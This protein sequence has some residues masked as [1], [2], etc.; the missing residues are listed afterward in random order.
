MK[1]NLKNKIVFI[2]GASSGIGK[3]LVLAFSS[4]DCF[5]I[6]CARR[7]K[8][9]QINYSKYKNILP[10]ELDVSNSN[11]VQEC[12]DR[13]L[14]EFGK[15]DILI[16]NAAVLTH[17]KVDKM[18]VDKWNDSIN[19]NISGVFYCC[20][21]I[22]PS[23]KE[24]NYGRIIN[25]SSGGSVNCGAEYSLYSLSKAAINAFTKS[26]GKELHDTNI[27]ANLMSPG[28]CRTDMFPENPLDPEKAAVPTAMML[29][30]IPE[31][32]PNG[33]FFWMEKEVPIIIDLSHI[34]WSDSNSLESCN[35]KGI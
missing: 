3:A 29:A 35:K 33:K 28:P 22:L 34:D 26:L 7:L 30:Q 18:A 31:N 10:L 21:Y 11:E 24:N 5:V 27:K 1:N 16:N 15:I 4:K 2:T 19:I 13:V 8:L 23:M 14:K 17:G 25:M 20:K 32:G 12:V 9:M 6:A